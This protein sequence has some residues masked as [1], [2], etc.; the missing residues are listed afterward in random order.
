MTID[1]ADDIANYVS[2]DPPYFDINGGAAAYSADYLMSMSLSSHPEDQDCKIML[3][4]SD[5]SSSNY[6]YLLIQDLS[7]IDTFLTGFTRVRLSDLNAALGVNILGRHNYGSK[8]NYYHALPKISGL[9]CV[10][11]L[12]QMLEACLNKREQELMAH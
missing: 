10:Q 1:D 12:Q 6:S 4:T 2:V 11:K 9:I 7:N 5:Q 3:Y 8:T